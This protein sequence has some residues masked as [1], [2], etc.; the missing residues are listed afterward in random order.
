MAV[1]TA[2]TKVATAARPWPAGISGAR[3]RRDFRAGA[4]CA[5]RLASASLMSLLALRLAGEGPGEPFVGEPVADRVLRRCREHSADRPGAPGARVVGDRPARP[6]RGWIGR[7]QRHGADAEPDTG[8]QQSDA[9]PRQPVLAGQQVA[10][11]GHEA[12][13]A[14]AEMGE[15]HRRGQAVPAGSLM[16]GAA[17]REPGAEHVDA[18]G[19]GDEPAVTSVAM[20]SQITSAAGAKGNRGV[21][22]AYLPELG[23]DRRG[24]PAVT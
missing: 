5:G 13:G 17:G 6:G 9:G 10:D 20:A 22:A 12:E 18:G 3:W 2:S 7:P 4:C 11:P 19:A 23:R 15:D 16:A 21:L 1:V 14:E 8:H 24:R